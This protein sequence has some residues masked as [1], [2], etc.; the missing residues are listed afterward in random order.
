MGMLKE[1]KAVINYF[2]QCRYMLYWAIFLF[3]YKAPACA[4]TIKVPLYR[5]S[6]GGGGSAIDPV[7]WQ[8]NSS[9]ESLWIPI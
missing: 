9:R 7:C 6:A 2:D 4:D 3:H 1:P 5:S 8:K